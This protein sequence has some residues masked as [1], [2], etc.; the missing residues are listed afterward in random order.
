MTQQLWPTPRRNSSHWWTASHRP[1]R[2]SDWPSVWKRR[3]SWDRT[4][5][6]PRSLPSTTMNS[7]LSP[8][9]HQPRLHHDWQPLQRSTRG[10]A[11]QL[12][13]SPV[14]RL[15]RGQDPSCIWRHRWQSTMSVL[16]AHCCMAAV[17]GLH[18]P[19]RRRLDA[20][21]LRSIRRILGISWQDK[22]TNADVLSRAGLPNMHTLLRQSR[23]RWLDDVRRMEDGCIPEDILYGELGLGRRTTGRPHLRYKYVG[24]RDMQQRTNEH[25]ERR[26]APPSDPKPHID[27]MSAIKTAIFPYWSFQP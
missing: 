2:N 3:M 17:H 25:A 20:F 19:G 24:V 15:R 8:S 21:H 23:L 14:S 26:A 9:V 11:R 12:Q 10:L 6:H 16:S 4:H 13:L 5:K 27:V 18:M 1:V 7:M 22:V